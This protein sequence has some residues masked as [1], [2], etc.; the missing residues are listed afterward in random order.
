MVKRQFILRASDC[1]AA[2]LPKKFQAKAVRLSELQP[3]KEPLQITATVCFLSMAHK[4]ANGAAKMAVELL[5][6]TG[7]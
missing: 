5:D 7:T 4:T 6:E 1:S 3:S 2:K